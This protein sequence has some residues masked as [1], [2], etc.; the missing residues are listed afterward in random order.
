MQKCIDVESARLEG[1]LAKVYGRLA[2][3]SNKRLLAAAEKRWLA[4]RTA[5]CKFAAS[6]NAG[7]SLAPIDAGEC[8]IDD[9]TQRVASLETYLKLASQG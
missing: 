6:R 9:T 5:D 4:Y 1:L 2:A 7:G 8:R 3:K